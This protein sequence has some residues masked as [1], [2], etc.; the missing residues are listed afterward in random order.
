MEVDVA[1]ERV[2]NSPHGIKVGFRGAMHNSFHAQ[3]RGR[4]DQHGRQR[5]GPVA[6]E[7]AVESHEDGCGF[8]SAHSL[9]LAASPRLARVSMREGRDSPQ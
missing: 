7:L 3:G 6:S 2:A 4:M 8:R 9:S 5:D 1:P